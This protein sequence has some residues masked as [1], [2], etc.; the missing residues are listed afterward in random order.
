MVGVEAQATPT[1]SEAVTTP[2]V[3]AE[4][5]LFPQR[6]IFGPLGCGTTRCLRTNEFVAGRSA[7]NAKNRRRT[8]NGIPSIRPHS[9]AFLPGGSFAAEGIS[10]PNRSE[11]L[12][13]GGR[14]LKL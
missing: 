10:N 4:R 3:A 5:V 1:S 14:D 11:P 9:S 2:R 6:R 12:Q 8:R 13:M 7:S